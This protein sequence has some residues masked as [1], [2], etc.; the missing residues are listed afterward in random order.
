M[1]NKVDLVASYWTFSGTLPGA[2]Q[3]FSRF[4]FRQRV[5]TVS[6]AGFTGVGIW[7]S[8]LEATL[9]QMPLTEMK[10]IL[11]DNG[12]TYVE[13]EFLVDWFLDGVRKQDS[14]LRKNLLFEA[15][16][17]LGAQTVKVGDFFGE[18]APMSRLI[19]TFGILCGQA[20]EAGTRIAFEPMSAA[21][22]HSLE[23]SLTMV[24]G[25]GADNGGLAIDLWHMV[26][27]G[28][29]FQDIAKIPKELLFAVE[30]NDAAYLPS[31]PKNQMAADPRRFCGE[32]DFDIQGFVDSIRRTGY[33][34][35]W[36]VEILSGELLE[37]PLEVIAAKAYATTMPFL[38]GHPIRPI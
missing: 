15:A 13:V 28:E 3:E 32:G 17:S 38:T 2:S 14:D 30:L 29:S 25:V 34:G 18:K 11:D 20:A 22:I 4:P 23:D 16:E 10:R 9:G 27:Q 1:K 37:M 7:H 24:R 5:E 33:S 8:D 35:P 12:I 19:D 21:M 31:R 36:G 26:N 6:R